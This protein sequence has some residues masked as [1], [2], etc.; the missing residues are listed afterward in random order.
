MGVLRAVGG[1]GADGA[2]SVLPVA[3]A[4]LR[5]VAGELFRTEDEVVDV[6]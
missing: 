4:V 6:V 2:D 1:A 3:T 5:A